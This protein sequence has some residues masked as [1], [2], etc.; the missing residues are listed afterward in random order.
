MAKVTPLSIIL[1]DA[2]GTLIYPQP[3]VGE[4]YAAVASWHGIHVSPAE[5]DQRFRVAFQRQEAVDAARGQRTDEARERDRWRQIVAEVFADQLHP[6]APFPDLWNHFAQPAHW[7]AYPDAQ[8]TLRRLAARGLRLAIASN[9]DGRLRDLVAGLPALAPIQEVFISSELGWKKP[10]LAFYRAI[11][12]RLA[13]A[14]AAV[15]VIGDDARR[16]AEAPRALGMT[17]ALIQRHAGETLD[18]VAAALLPA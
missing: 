18:E 15:L 8:Q 6:E 9:F 5:I 17:A 14:P 12:D 3:P 2:V 4:A 1:F 16:D 11:L 13:V 10:A 7:A